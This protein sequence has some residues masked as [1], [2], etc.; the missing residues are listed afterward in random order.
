MVRRR[1]DLNIS[2][3]DKAIKAIKAGKTEEAL[4]NL[5]EVNEQFHHLNDLYSN[6]VSRAFGLL[7]RAYGEEWL[8]DFIRDDTLKGFTMAYASWKNQTPEQKVEGI[9]A[10][11]RAHYSEFHVEEDDE[12]FTVAITGCNAGGRLLRD[13]I[14]K[15]E[16]AVTKKAYP[17]AFNTAGF[18]YYCIHATFINEVFRNLNLKM[19]IQW[20][21][22]YDEQGN[23]INDPCRYLIYK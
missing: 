21:R 23:K 7:A 16:G 19:K 6:D 11:H 2:P 4:K 5:E 9:C 8:K 17:W 15:K 12:K 20:G 14:A 3:K 18:P 1:D 10:V 13:G 22:Q